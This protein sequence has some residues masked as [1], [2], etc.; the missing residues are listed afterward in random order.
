MTDVRDATERDSN[1]LF[2]LARRFATSFTPTSDGFR[3]SLH[4]VLDS[5]QAKVL[6]V[7]IDGRIV[8]YLLGFIHP[9]FFAD[10]PVAWI[11]ELMIDEEHRG[12][13]L[14]RLLVRAFE[15]WARQGEAR[16]V[17]LA[18]RRASEFY[19]RLGYEESATYHRRLLNPQV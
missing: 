7:E 19:L 3:A 14:G 1:E 10:G 8:G 17:A 15:A 11:E 9:T 12:F 13:G 2:E 18:T 5:Q 6:V 4:Q 16:L